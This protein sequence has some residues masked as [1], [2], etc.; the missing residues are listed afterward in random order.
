ME[1]RPLA[2][3]ALLRVR[4]E[5]CVLESFVYEAV[6]PFVEKKGL[7]WVLP[8]RETL[9]TVIAGT[10]FAVALNFI[11]FGTTRILAVL[12]IYHDFIVGAPSRLIGFAIIPDPP[13]P[14]EMLS[15]ARPPTLPLDPR[16]IHTS[17][18]R[19]PEQCLHLIRV[20][21]SV[22]R[23][24]AWVSV[25]AAPCSPSPPRRR[26]SSGPGCW[27]VWRLRVR[28]RRPVAARRLGLSVGQAA[29]CSPSPPR[30]RLD[31]TP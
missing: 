18:C 12:S 17:V 9:D 21:T 24:W 5:I 4:L 29:P 7:G 30:R 11:L 22:L 8:F 10:V 31:W 23:N 26:P 16:C 3:E 28:R 13:K 14:K 27:L 20:L 25:W 19:F 6:V 15:T 2:I 1:Y